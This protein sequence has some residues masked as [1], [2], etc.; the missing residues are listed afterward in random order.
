MAS[1]PRTRVQVYRAEVHLNSSTVLGPPSAS[2]EKRKSVLIGNDA[3]Q[4]SKNDPLLKQNKLSREGEELIPAVAQRT[5]TA[6]SARPFTRLLHATPAA[7]LTRSSD[8]KMFEPR[9]SESETVGVATASTSAIDLVG[10]SREDTSDWRCL[11]GGTDRQA[12]TVQEKFASEIGVEQTSFAASGLRNEEDFH[13][14]AASQA[15]ADASRI[16]WDLLD[17]PSGLLDTLHRLVAVNEHNH[18]LQALFLLQRGIKRH[19]DTM[20]ECL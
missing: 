7:R 12:F 1:P 20:K 9:P 4:A 6:T 11:I 3:L 18:I 2:H 13:A 15:A 17:D 16:P 8:G 19:A 10:D 14:V 5:G